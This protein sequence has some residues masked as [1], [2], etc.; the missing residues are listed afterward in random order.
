MLRVRGKYLLTIASAVWVFAGLN[1]LRLGVLAC[2]EGSTPIWVMAAGIP[3]IFLIFHLMFSKLVGK[4]S[5]RIRG[6][7]E[8]RTHV[9]RFFDVKGYVIMAVMM[10]GGISLR[11][12]GLV[13]TWF[14]AFFYTGVG[15]ALA[16]AG[17]GFMIHFAKRGGYVMCP[18][19]K[20][21][22]LA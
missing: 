9:L 15:I 20:K 6:Y 22:R 3:L 19:T 5:D 16:L 10:G 12:F 13:P 17:I 4:H 18:V 8:E 1:V 21:T 7:G 2:L 14:V 11:A